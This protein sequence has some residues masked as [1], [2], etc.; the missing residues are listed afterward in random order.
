M[1]IFADE[2]I[3]WL[4]RNTVCKLLGHKSS[5]R[6][7]EEWAIAHG[8]GYEVKVCKRC[9]IELD[10]RGAVYTTQ[11]VDAS[12]EKPEYFTY[13]VEKAKERQKKCR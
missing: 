6:C 5:E 2:F 7:R 9:G 8:T 13:D 4:N 12:K 10:R 1:K 11:Y 3:R